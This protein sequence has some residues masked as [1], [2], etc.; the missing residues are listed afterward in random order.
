MHVPEKPLRAAI[1][2]TEGELDADKVVWSVVP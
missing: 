2:H 1:F